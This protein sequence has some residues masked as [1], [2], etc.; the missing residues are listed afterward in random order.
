LAALVIE[1]TPAIFTILQTFRGRYGVEPYVI[2]PI[3]AYGC[4]IGLAILLWTGADRFAGRERPSTGRTTLTREGLVAAL[5]S[6]IG[7]YLLADAFVTFSSTAL[8][9]GLNQS[10]PKSSIA[11]DAANFWV[12]PVTKGI[13]GLGLFLG[14]GGF[15]RDPNEN[16]EGRPN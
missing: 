3:A 6:A 9:A 13:V 10:L 14:Y 1:Q 4:L 5:F 16:D 15:W 12:V 8:V 2:Y 7:L 11:R